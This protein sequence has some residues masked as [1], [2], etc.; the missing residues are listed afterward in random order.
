MQMRMPAALGLRRLLSQGPAEYRDLRSRSSIGSSRGSAAL[1]GA[2][3]R[4]TRELLSMRLK[5]HPHP[6]R[7]AQP[8]R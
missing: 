6:R 8:S 1:A 4:R 5:L 2:V 7:K 3:A